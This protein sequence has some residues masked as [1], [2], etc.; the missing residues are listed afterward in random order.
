VLET[1]G[2]YE[3]R[4]RKA[5][6]DRMHDRAQAWATLAVASEVQRVADALERLAPHDEREQADAE[7]D[8]S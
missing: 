8:P 3:E 5:I 2:Y 4:A 6:G 1:S 7:F